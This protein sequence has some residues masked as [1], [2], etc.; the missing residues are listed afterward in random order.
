M[1]FNR[2]IVA[3]SLFARQI[4][5]YKIWPP[6]RS[7]PIHRDIYACIIYDDN[8]YGVSTRISR[9]RWTASARAKFTNTFHST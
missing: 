3:K 4:K 1:C 6:K 7:I 9:S 5:I 8:T 2:T